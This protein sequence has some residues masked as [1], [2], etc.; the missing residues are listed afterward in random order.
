MAGA[1]LIPILYFHHTVTF[2]D[3][4]DQHRQALRLGYAAS[5]FFL[6]ADTTPWFV[7]DVKS[8]LSFPYWPE[9]GPLFHFYLTWFAGYVLYA[10]YLVAAAFHAAS[11]IRR[12]QYAY[13]LAASIIGYAGGATNFPLWYGIPIAPYGTILITLYTALMAY[14]IVRY[15]LMNI[16]V[17]LNKGLAY[18]I[19]LGIIV[20]AT[21][22]GA[23]LSNRATAHSTPPL[24]AGTLFLIC[25][26][27]GIGQQRQR[28][29][30][31]HVQP[32]VRS[33]L[34]VAV[35]LFHALF[36]R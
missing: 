19:V 14:T 33:G 29:R 9:P 21:S 27:L 23:V 8:A 22:I 32:I 34:S 6:I 16:S 35:R 25:G 11:G 5:G 17:V 7:A 10:T 1:I 13:M 15:R 20:V 18:A 30:Q 4:V 36:S 12:H 2:L 26:L 31:C 3:T 28:G 24:L